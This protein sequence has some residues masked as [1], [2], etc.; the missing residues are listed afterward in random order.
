[1]AVAALAL[2]VAALALNVLAFALNVLA[3]ALYVADFALY[4]AD[5]ALYVADFTDGAEAPAWLKS[6]LATLAF[7]VVLR[8]LINDFFWIDIAE[9]LFI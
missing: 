1:L 7:L 4:V 6:S 3:L 9:L 2:S 8:V 5:F